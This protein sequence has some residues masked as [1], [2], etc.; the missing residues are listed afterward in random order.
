MASTTKL[1]TA[2]LFCEKVSPDTIVTAGQD[3]AS[4]GQCS[5]HL[6]LGEKLTAHDLLRGMLLRSANDAAVAAADAAAGSVPNFVKLM[7]AEAVALGCYHTHFANPNGLTAPDHYTTA[8]DLSVIARA[9]MLVSRIR[10]VV[11]LKEAVIHRSID[12]YD[13]VMRNHTHFVGF[14]KGANGIKTGWTDPAGHCLVGSASRNGWDLISVVLHDRNFAKDTM[15]LM[16]YG[17]KYFKPVTI[18]PADTYSGSAVVADGQKREVP[19]VTDAPVRV[20]E[21]KSD[22]LPVHTK[23]VMDRLT[24]PVSTG[25]IAGH[26]DVYEGNMLV[27]S[28]GLSA[29]STDLALNSDKSSI[30]MLPAFAE[31]LVIVAG[32]LVSLGYGT[33]II[34]IAK[35]ARRRWSG[36]QKGLRGDH[37]SG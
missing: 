3:A 32:I 36:V 9:A 21:L 35:S 30:A 5:M 20:I 8:R 29:N 34:K 37:R 28:I 16:N 7:N 11:R 24:A 6:K 4:T 18:K 2:I 19:L 26:E 12:Q 1:M 10:H 14:Y 27:D 22:P 23:L 25:E 13:L 17:F 33:R 15:A 31:K